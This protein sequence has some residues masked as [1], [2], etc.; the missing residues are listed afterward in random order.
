MNSTILFAIGSS[1]LALVYG[2]VAA[3]RL[4][5][6]DAGSDRMKEISAAIAQGAKAYLNRQYKT[7]AVIG[8]AVA[9]ILFFALGLKSAIGFVV[10]AALSAAAGYIGMNVSVRANSRVAQA[11][12]DGMNPVRSREGTERAS[13]SNGMKPA[14]ALAFQ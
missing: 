10:G 11:A 8:I 2:A 1:L 14:L 3:S 4:L 6:K 13:A 12:A 9:V 5:K 7:I